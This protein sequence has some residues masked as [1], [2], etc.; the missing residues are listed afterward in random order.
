MLRFAKH[1]LWFFLS[2]H[3]LMSVWLILVISAKLGVMFSY[4]LFSRSKPVT[5][6]FW[7]RSK[8]QFGGGGGGGK[9]IGFAGM[10]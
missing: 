8:E 4:L 7:F 2:S 3:Q 5:V 10:V 9:V 6:L 1:I